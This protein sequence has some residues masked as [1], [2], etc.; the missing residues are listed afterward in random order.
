MVETPARLKKID[1]DSHFFPQSDFGDLDEVL[2]GYSKEAFD[3]LLRDAA[4][5]THPNP[6]RGG[7]HKSDAGKEVGAVHPLDRVQTGPQGHGIA[8]DRI[9]LLPQ[10]GFDMQVLIPDGIFGNPFMTE[11]YTTITRQITTSPITHA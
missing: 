3:M 11:R 9:K 4:L 5:F 1:A 8:E 6:R 7:F 2:K 10:T